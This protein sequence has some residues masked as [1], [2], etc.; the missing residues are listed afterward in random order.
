LKEKIHT[1]LGS[2]ALLEK[3]GK[4]KSP[5]PPSPKEKR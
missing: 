3:K 5:Q 2:G 1:S 4:N